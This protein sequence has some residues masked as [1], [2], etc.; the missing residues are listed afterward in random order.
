MSSKIKRLPFALLVALIGIVLLALPV[1][2]IAN[3]DGITFGTG[4]VERYKAFYNVYEDDDMLF[5]AETD[6]DYASE[7]TDYTAEEAFLF[8]LMSADLATVHRAVSMP[9]WQNKVISIYLTAA[10]VTSLSLSTGTAYWLRMTGNPSIFATLTEGTN[11]VSKQL[12]IGTGTTLD[13]SWVDQSAATATANPLREFIILIANNLEAHD[14]PST[15]YLSVVQGTTYL[16]TAGGNIF[17]DG[18]PDLRQFCPSAFASTTAPIEV[19]LPP[20]TGALQTDLAI[21]GKLGTNT[22]S[23]FTNLGNWLGI[24]QR[25]AGTLAL[26]LAMLMLCVYLYQKTKTPM[27]TV[28]VIIAVAVFGAYLGLVSLAV[29][30]VIVMAVVVAS[31]YLFMSKGTL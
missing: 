8:E 15:S 27:A 31:V 28:P 10:Q 29:T 21:L 25:T 4:T 30:L 5:I 13:V 18:I 11:M 16:S 24:P 2:A 20:A 7:P 3:P 6:L 23:A 9:D 26:M 12:G 17:L 22:S 14:S 19:V 1:Y